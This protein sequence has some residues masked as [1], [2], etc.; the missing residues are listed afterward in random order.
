[1]SPYIALFNARLSTLVQYRV[2]AFAGFL[3]QIFWGLIKSM[4]LTA[5]F[6]EAKGPEPITLTQGITFIW[7]GQGFLQLLPW[8]IDKEI[9]SD[10]R[11]GNVA[12]ELVRPLDLYTLWF[13][14]ALAMR[15]V[16]TLMRSPFLLLIAYL[17][18]GLPL[19]GSFLSGL[20]FLGS[21]FFAAFLSSA[22]TTLV[23]TTLFWT[24]SGEGILRLLPHFT[25][26]LSGLV[27]PLPLFPDWMKPII[28]VQPFRGII[29]IPSR[30]YTGVIPL[31]EVLFYYA[32]QVFWILILVL[33]G[34][35]LIGRALK[36]VVIQGG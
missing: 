23:H 29:D 1:M 5:F 9:E 17:F 11:S 35:Y 34:K 25:I 24:I 22:I 12:Y 13:A 33:L 32:F 6:L 36:K 10:I 26:V 2:A 14:R 28:N 18:F 30:I 21:L 7:L 3:T 16:L 31:N 19:P 4:I 27:V 15:V 8:N 20:A